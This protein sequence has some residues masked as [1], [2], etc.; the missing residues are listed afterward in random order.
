MGVVK[1]MSINPYTLNIYILKH[2]D[3]PND[4]S[5]GVIDF[6]GVNSEY[7]RARGIKKS[8]YIECIRDEQ[9][10]SLLIKRFDIWTDDANNIV[11][12]IALYLDIEEFNIIAMDFY[13]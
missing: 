1:F 12:N 13:T 10:I 2:I 7:D 5:Y 6:V 3:T 11:S 8:R 4:S 9:A